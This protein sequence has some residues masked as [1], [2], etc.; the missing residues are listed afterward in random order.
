MNARQAAKAASIRIQDLERINKLYAADVKDYY[1][2]IEGTVDGE[3]ICKW[4]DDHEECQ[5]QAKDGKGCKEWILKRQPPEVTH[6][7]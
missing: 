2:C 4:C 3:S 5:L 7:S 6:E 1:E